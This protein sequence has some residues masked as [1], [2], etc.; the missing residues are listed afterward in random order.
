M[1]QKLLVIAG[2]TAVG[3]TA[4]AISAARQMGGE[5]I[6]ADSMQIYRYM[7][8]GSAKPT[9]EEQEKAVHHLIDSI[10]PG[11]E[12]SVAEYQTLAKEAICE[13][14]KKG[15]LPIICGGTGLYINSLLYSMNFG[16]LPKQDE[17]R[18]ELEAIG[19][20]EGNEALH[21]I[22]Q[23]VDAEAAA[24]IH[25]NNRKKIIRAIEVAENSGSGIPGF[26]HAFQKTDD[27][28]FLFIGLIREREELY[29][30]INLRVDLLMEQGLLE[31][32]KGLMEQGLTEES[33]SMKGIGYKELI[34][35]LNGEY[36]LEEA[37]RLIK[38]NTRRYAKRQI[39]WFKRDPNI[40][41]FWLSEKLSFTENE[42]AFLQFLKEEWQ[43]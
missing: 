36:D 4:Y 26:E 32:V 20:K 23:K 34:A 40:R 25:P 41:W 14:F 8:I 5:I 37:V 22:L 12:F 30:R 21:E 29:R 42:T 24:R 33:I 9:P 17:R 38:R 27:Y 3:K 13:V 11:K 2:P 35:C 15:K 31:E 43:R 39:T 1:K 10:D 18:K 28:D 6:S 16:I 7:D 19:E